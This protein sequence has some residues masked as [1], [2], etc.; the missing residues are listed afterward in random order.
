[1]TTGG[2]INDTKYSNPAVDKELNASRLVYDVAARKAHFD[3]AAKIL[4]DELPL[5]YLYLPA[6]IWARLLLGGLVFFLVVEAEKL[7]IRTIRSGRPAATA[8]SPV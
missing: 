5:V 1:M 4:R 3:A 7:I 2:G 8:E 6:W